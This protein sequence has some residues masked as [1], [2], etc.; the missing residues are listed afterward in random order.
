MINEQIKNR[1]PNEMKLSSAARVALILLLLVGSLPLWAQNSKNDPPCVSS[2]IIIGNHN[3][4][5]E[6]IRRE[7]LFK[8]GQPLTDSLLTASKKRLENLWLFNRVELIK[9]PRQDSVTVVVAVTERLH[10]YPYP[11]FMVDDRD[12]NKLTYGFGFANIN[13][14]GM[15][16]KLY[17]NVLFGHHKGFLFSYL[18]PWIGNAH[19]FTSGIFVQ[20]F[21]QI[22]RSFNFEENHFYGAV[23]LGKFW[24]LYFVTRLTFFSDHIRVPQ[25]WQTEMLSG[26][27]EETNNGVR[28]TVIYDRRDLY[29]Y[30]SRG[31]MAKFTVTQN[32]LFNPDINYLQ[33]LADLRKYFNYHGIILATRLY[34]KQSLGDLPVYDR[35]YL[36]YVERI[37]GH[38]YQ[39]IEGRHAFS[40]GVGLR[41]PLLPVRYFSLPAAL[42]PESST[43]NLK[44]GINMGLFAESGM[45]WSRRQDFSPKNFI[46][47]FG[48]GLH[49]LLPYVEVV[50]ADLAFDEKLHSQ[51]LIEVL[52]PF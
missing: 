35:V 51:F 37:R 26:R 50:R 24:N 44:F 28:L 47:G 25:G 31:W 33:Y 52:M 42:V 2:I 1:K 3:T 17:A 45:V 32:G 39:V 22:N 18:N 15:N 40:V 38:F 46:S 14:R 30:P 9:M 4:R 8:K 36:G 16:E 20:K 48:V 10:L 13:F 41:F 21:D 27:R 5:P 49:F 19:H 43:R 6:V 23:S 11:I 34:T 29:A 7:L 12:W